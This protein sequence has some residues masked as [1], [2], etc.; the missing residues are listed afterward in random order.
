M[1][2]YQPQP[3]LVIK[4][5]FLKGRHRF[6]EM[7]INKKHIVAIWNRLVETESVR[8]FENTIL[9]STGLEIQVWLDDLACTLENLP[10]I[11]IAK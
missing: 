6:D 3:T 11:L 9:L 5:G 2:T 4:N 10:N 1:K 7:E 8:Y